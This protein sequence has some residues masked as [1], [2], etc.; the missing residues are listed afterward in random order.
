MH[1]WSSGTGDTGVSIWW[2]PRW[3]INSSTHIDQWPR[4]SLQTVQSH[5]AQG[6]MAPSATRPDVGDGCY[7]GDA[8]SQSEPPAHANIPTQGVPVPVVSVFPIYPFY[9]NLMALLEV[10]PPS[11]YPSYASQWNASALSSSVQE[12]P[13]GVSYANDMTGGYA[14]RPTTQHVAPAMASAFPYSAPQ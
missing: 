12:Q 3:D 7:R 4:L 5:K 13:Y 2:G 8:V 1:I 10:A 9:S 14:I 11:H 6:L